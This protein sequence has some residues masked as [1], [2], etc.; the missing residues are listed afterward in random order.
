[1][2]VAVQCESALLQ[3]SL[4]LF[5]DTH[6]SSLKQ[7][8]V[9]IRDKKIMDAHHSLFVS[10]SMQADIKKPFSRSQLYLT[11]EKFYNKMVDIESVQAYDEEVLNSV[12]NP[13]AA[14]EQQIEIITQEYKNKILKTV[15]AFYE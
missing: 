13:Y 5:L 7:C 12:Q 2:K 6:L 11:L 4:E 1:M 3:R 10:S 8:D 9:V 15:K 14:L